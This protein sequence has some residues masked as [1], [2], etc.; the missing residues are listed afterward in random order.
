MYFVKTIKNILYSKNCVLK[1]AFIFIYLFAFCLFHAD[2][3]ISADSPQVL[4]RRSSWQRN[5]GKLNANSRT[6]KGA[7]GTQCTHTTPPIPTKQKVVTLTKPLLIYG[8]E[9]SR[10]GPHST[11]LPHNGKGQAIHHRWLM[12]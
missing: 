9:P 8:A 11:T 7:G 6:G 2:V 10:H 12:L 1:K 3:S 4:T 5:F